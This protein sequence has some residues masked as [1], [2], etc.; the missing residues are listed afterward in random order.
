MLQ[1]LDQGMGSDIACTACYHWNDKVLQD[2]TNFN[3]LHR[4]GCNVLFADGS[5]RTLN[6]KNRDGVL[7]NGFGAVGEFSTAEPD[8]GE[9][10]IFS[11]FSTDAVQR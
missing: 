10:D 4:G 11:L 5:V 7:N 1:Q 3:P 6:D 8:V 9:T 2:Y